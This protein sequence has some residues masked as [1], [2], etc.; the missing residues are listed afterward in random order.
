MKLG[1]RF[2]NH[3]A[4]GLK[5]PFCGDTKILCVDREWNK[6]EKICSSCWIKYH[7]KV[8]ME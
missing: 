7:K 1:L 6:G 4:I 5:C 3:P 8:K 2:L